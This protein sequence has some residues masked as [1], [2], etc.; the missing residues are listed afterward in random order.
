MLSIVL[1]GF[2]QEKDHSG[3][4]AATAAH[5]FDRPKSYREAARVLV[6]R[7]AIAI[8]CTFAVSRNRRPRQQ[9]A[10]LT[11]FGKRKVCDRPSGVLCVVE[12]DMSE[13]CDVPST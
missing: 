4:T 6:Q 11:K 3:R 5:W 13:I 10:F 1:R 12:A 7:G 2:G 8:V 9:P